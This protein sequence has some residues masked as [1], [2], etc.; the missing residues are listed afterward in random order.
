MAKDWNVSKLQT[1]RQCRRKLY[2]GYE[3]AQSGFTFPFRRKAWELAKMKTLKMWQGSVVDWVVTSEVMPRY[4]EGSRPDFP[5]IADEAVALAKRQFAFSAS[6]DYHRSD[7]VRSE[8]GADWM[9]LD[10]H[11]WKLPYN[12]QEITDIYGR[13]HEII[14]NFP[15][16]ASPEPALTLDEYLYSSKFLRPDAKKLKYEYGD[17]KIQPQI[18]LVRY[19]GKSIHVIDWKVTERDDADYSRQLI[20]GGVVALHFARN[21]YAKMNWNP[22]PVMEDTRLF[23]IN[24]LGGLVKEHPFTETST[25]HALDS[26]YL[27][28]DEQEQ[29]SKDK[30]WNELDLDDY[31]LTDKPE[32]CMICKFKLLCKHLLLNDLNYDEE[33]YLKLVQHRQLARAEI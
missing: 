7:I 4:Q 26:V 3:I 5:K 12:E 15:G 21:W 32:T 27:L 2:F 10:I 31:P 30:P 28:S 22:K 16:Y 19:L 24:L 8:V 17:V 33:N 1:L 29:M 25:A 9:I 11:E 18:D 6:G 20:L 14:S 13:I 23:E